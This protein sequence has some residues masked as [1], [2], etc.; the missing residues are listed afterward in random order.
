[1]VFSAHSVYEKQEDV[2]W[3]RTSKIL[4]NDARVLRFLLLLRL[5]IIKPTRVRFED[6]MFVLHRDFLL[7]NYFK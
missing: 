2:T 5:K 7:K 3:F 4:K 6:V 1:M